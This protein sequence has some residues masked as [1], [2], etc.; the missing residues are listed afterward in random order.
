M[1][2]LPNCKEL[3]QLLSPD[4]ERL[5]GSGGVKLSCGVCGEDC[6]EPFF[7]FGLSA[8]RSEALVNEFF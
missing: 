1:L 4:I 7:D 6:C 2:V 8:S 5:L 3:L